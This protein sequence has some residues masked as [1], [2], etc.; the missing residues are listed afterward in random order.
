M[1]DIKN[2]KAGIN[3][4]YD[5]ICFNK[6]ITLSLLRLD[7]I[8]PIISG[9]KIFKLHYFLQKAIEFK[10]KII[11]FGGAY[12]NHLVATAAACKHSGLE[13]IGIVRGEKPL[14]LS[15]T[16]LY[17]SQHG[18]HIEFMS[19]NAYKQKEKT[20]FLES[21][22]VKFGEHILIPEG[23][24][25]NEGVQGAAEIYKHIPK[26]FTHI[27][28]SAG[29][30]TTIA[31]LIQQASPS[32]QIVGFSA[33][34]G[35]NFNERLTCLLNKP[36]PKNYSMITNYHFGGYAKK[37]NSLISFMNT[38][39]ENHLIP[40]DFVYTGK[41]MY[42]VIDMAE[43]NY[44]PEKSRIICIHSGGLQGNSSLMPGVLKY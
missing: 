36:L 10:L 14:D 25:S 39:Y 1:L 41:M 21:L 2:I 33:L 31:G 42:G 8:H 16:L 40:L 17:C 12:S 7:E 22:R 3:N 43:Q 32:Q 35:I 15:S 6:N 18:M 13:C 4:I 28:C 19:R 30:G 9:N 27:C 26:E 23:G 24:F 5:G 29:T 20:G 34:K 37:T 11:T 44:F 38:F